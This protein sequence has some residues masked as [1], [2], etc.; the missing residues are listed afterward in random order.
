M[1]VKLTTSPQLGP[2]KECVDLYIHSLIRFKPQCLIIKHWGKLYFFN[3][4]IK[5]IPHTHIY[6]YIYVVNLYMEENES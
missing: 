3:V 2:W 5:Y 6:I 4:I 1:G